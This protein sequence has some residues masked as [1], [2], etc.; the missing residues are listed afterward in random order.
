MDLRE[1]RSEIEA[2]EA[3][4]DDARG[5]LRRLSKAIS[6]TDPSHG[7]PGD[8]RNN[9]EEREEQRRQQRPLPVTTNEEGYCK[10]DRV[11]I[12]WDVVYKKGR[13]RSKM[14][15]TQDQGKEAVLTHVTPK[16]VWLKVGAS[17]PRRKASHNVYLLQ[18]A[19]GTE[20]VII[21]SPGKPD[22]IKT[23][24]STD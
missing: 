23:R 5:R 10:G 16:Q 7:E 15:A 9:E 17:S 4:L 8:E 2:I 19:P 20:N 22:V 3:T 13:P 11:C 6:E 14:P 12:G 24:V 1:L 21:R 18:A